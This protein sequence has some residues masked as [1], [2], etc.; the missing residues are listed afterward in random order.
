[1]YERK[2]GGK[3]ERKHGT[4]KPGRKGWKNGW[5]DGQRDGQKKGARVKQLQLVRE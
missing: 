3:G 1:M 5:M 2:D 4:R